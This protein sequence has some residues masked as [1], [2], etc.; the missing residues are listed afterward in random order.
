MVST[1]TTP[2]SLLLIPNYQFPHPEFKLKFPVTNIL[3]AMSLR[4]E[5]LFDRPEL[6][7]TVIRWWHSVWSDRMGSDFAN[8]EHQLLNSLSKTEFP[9]HVVAFDEDEAVAV[10]ALKF[11]E[12]EDIF[13]DHTYWLGSVFVAEAH[14][15]K[16]LGS[17]IT[18]RVVDVAT[19]RDL[20]Q[21]YLQ[22]QNLSGG[23]Y[24]KMGWEPLQQ[25]TINDEETL[26]MVKPL[27]KGSGI[28]GVD[29]P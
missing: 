28:E 14:R 3:S 19:E 25:L 27:K 24:K 8:L 26:L 9:T 22:T 10:A 15:H 21:L 17:H 29:A 16:Q 23:L 1:Q 12:L 20:P 4:F 2:N 6:V 18:Q 7:P 11:Q 5:Y 13:P